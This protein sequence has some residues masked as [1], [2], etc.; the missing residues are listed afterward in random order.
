MFLLPVVEEPEANIA[1][2][3]FSPKGLY[4]RGLESL[5]RKQTLC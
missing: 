5:L 3:V 4:L 2:E 1:L